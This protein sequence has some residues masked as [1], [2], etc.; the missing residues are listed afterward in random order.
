MISEVLNCVACQSKKIKII[1]LGSYQILTCSRCRLQRAEGNIPKR[2]A[3]TESIN[4][5][6]MS[7]K[8]IGAP[9]TYEPYQ[10]F[11]SYFENLYPNRKLRILDIGCGAGGFI[12]YSVSRGHDCSGVEIDSNLQPFFPEKIRQRIIISPIE[13]LQINKLKPFDV[14]TFWDSFEH[15]QFPFEVLEKLNFALTPSGT[16]YLRVNNRWDIY[17]LVTDFLRH[18]SLDWH[19][20]ILVKCFGSENTSFPHYWNFSKR[21]MFTIL[22]K[23]WWS[24][25]HHRFTETVASRFTKNKILILIFNIAYLFNKMIGGGKIAEY[26]IRQKNTS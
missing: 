21:A 16:I 14:I 5:H 8:S 19:K 15:L 20:K 24:V 6:Y 10:D 18:I 22:E 2:M 3:Q 25:I 1:N 11:F 7:K 26:Y 4:A 9:N 13:D 23:K 17:N 12:E